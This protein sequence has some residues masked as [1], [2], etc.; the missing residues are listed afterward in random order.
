MVGKKQQNSTNPNLTL[1]M[2][3]QTQQ[4]PPI[5]ELVGHLP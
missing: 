4:N 3:G 1:D 2:V 5:H